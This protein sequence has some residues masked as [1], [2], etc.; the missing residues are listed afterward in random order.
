MIFDADVPQSLTQVAS[1][2]LRSNFL[3][4]LTHHRGALSPVDPRNG[5]IWFD[6]SDPDNLKLHIY[7][8]AWRT[9]LEDIAL[10]PPIQSAPGKAVHVQSSA[11][12]SWNVSHGLG[13]G[14]VVITVFDAVG[15]VT[16]PQS[17]L[18]I[19]ENTLAVTF[20]S[21]TAGRAV[22]LG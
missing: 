12:A 19:D 20:S 17:I 10:G 6:T 13:T 21:P 15:Q 16:S 18:S 8:N 3:S 9:I 2:E 22:V 4:L 14:D 11:A 5:M 1:E 7:E